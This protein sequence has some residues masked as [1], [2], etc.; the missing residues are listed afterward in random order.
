[1]NPLSRRRTIA[2]VLSAVAF[3]SLIASHAYA[4]DKNDKKKKDPPRDPV[5]RA[6][7][8]AAL[9]EEERRATDACK[10]QSERDEDDQKRRVKEIEDRERGN[11]TSFLR[12][13]ILDGMW[14]PMSGGGQY[15]LIGAHLDVASIG[16]IHLFGPPGVLMMMDKSEGSSRLRP[17]WTWGVSIYLTEFEFPGSGRRTQLF[18]NLAK[19]WSAGDART[20]RDLCGLSLA[21]KK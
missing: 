20:G 14:V 19:A 16:R 18:F 7:Y 4:A 5:E 8:C 6:E 3:L 12:K 17:A 21:W 10:T 9:P 2:N 11:K 15:G 1:M 13:F